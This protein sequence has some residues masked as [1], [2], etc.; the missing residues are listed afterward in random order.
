MDELNLLARSLP[1]APPP[2]AEVVEKARARLSAAQHG[3]VRPGRTDRRGLAWGWTLGAAAATVAVIM[4]VATLVSNVT[5]APAPVLVPAGGN[6]A[7]LRLADQVAKLPDEGGD[8]WR[9]PLLNNG[10]IRVRAG[11]ETFNVL[12]SSRID[13][14]QPRDPRDPVQVEQWELSVRPATPA[15]ERAWRAAGSPVTVQRV[16][17]PGTR[18]GDCTE[19]RLRSKPS[20]CVYTR[21]A[22]PGGVLGDRRL[23]ELTLADLAALPGDAGQL[24]EKLRTFWKTRQ[25]SQSK[26]SFE[27]F[28]ST[29]SAL[30]EL[31]VR[32]SVRAAA[33]R[34]LAGLPTTNVRGSI[35]DP[36][37]RPGIAVTFVKSEGFFA[38]FGTDQVAERYT[39]ILDP[40]TGTVL[41]HSSIAAE[42]V[43]GLA[44][45]TFMHYQAWAP[46]AGW[47]SE[48]PE[49][50]RGCRLSDRPLP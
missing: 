18:A 29:S 3:P 48:R 21:A 41:A 7:L 40:R 11:G 26:D 30:L 38:E 45:G 33:L 10:L 27:E 16:C 36:L 24:R 20:G 44:K 14:W 4:A 50:P 5:A 23:G 35:T 42:S 2:S 34:L 13:L 12:S 31:P 47:T 22:E 6:D 49:R 37:G 19:V 32:P 39:T 17:T 15:D 25:D 43:E 8:Y 46:E 1:D 28:L 9:R